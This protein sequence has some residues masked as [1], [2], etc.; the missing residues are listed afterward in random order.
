MKV[1]FASLG[2]DK[3]KVDSEKILKF[4]MKKKNF[5]IV[6]S[7]D[8]ADIA[9]LNT[10]SFI[11][12]AKDE[13]VSWIKYLVSLKK[14]KRLQKIMVL[15]CLATEYMR[16]GRIYA[17]TKY[18]YMHNVR[19]FVDI[20][21]DVD[22]ILPLEKY[23]YGL[24]G[25]NDRVCD[26]LSF[27]S[28]IKICD[29]CDKYCSYCIIPYLRGKFKSNGKEN[30]LK[31]AK[32]LAKAGVKEL[33]IVGQDVLNY[34]NDLLT[35][36]QHGKVSR[37]IVELINDIAKIK[38][39][40]WIRLLYCYPEAIDDEV[41]RLIRDNDKVIPYIDMPIQH[42]SDKILKSMNRKTT[43]ASIR[44]LIYKLRAMIPDVVI[45]TTLMVGFP[46]ET[47][48]DF[49]EL[50]DFV[51]EMRFDKLGVFCYSREKLSRA[52]DFPNQVSE[53]VKESRRKKI[54]DIQKK[55]VNDKNKEHLGIVYYSLVEG[56][57][58]KKRM[59]IVRPYFNA[60]GIDDNI[61]VDTR[62][63]LISGTFVNVEIKKVSGMDLI[64]SIV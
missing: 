57:D 45:R 44:G 1:F 28:F 46:G 38:G 39:I 49:N 6:D 52:Y 13:S 11:R 32:K 54:L 63:K 40:E 8:G 50:C 61:Y 43:S 21:C 14:K 30:I 51:W 16:T 58:T 7:P 17:S 15:G 35:K 12:D 31:E 47:E 23:L 33:N 18:S 41:I 34:G 55:I 27:S 62:E 2:C 64:G 5:K 19:P 10:C 42:I 59:Y 22:V 56:F 36:E 25:L 29:G 26:I 48:N 9:I 4:F 24:N 60:R 53:D 20:M 37:P 3:N